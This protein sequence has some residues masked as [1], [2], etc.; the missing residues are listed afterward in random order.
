[1]QWCLC[2]WPTIV[3]FCYAGASGCFVLSSFL[4]WKAI[5][6][7]SIKYSWKYMSLLKLISQ[8]ESLKLILSLLLIRNTQGSVMSS[9]FCFFGEPV[10]CLVYISLILPFWS[11]SYTLL[12]LHLCCLFCYQV[13]CF[14]A[15]LHYV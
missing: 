13:S 6:W 10:V 4:T 14:H 2:F 5:L 7:F 3:E 11:C 1:M 12:A 9:F 8:T 15:C